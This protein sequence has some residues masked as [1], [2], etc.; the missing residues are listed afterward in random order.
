MGWEK[1]VQVRRFDNPARTGSTTGL[2]RTRASGLVYVQV[3]W[4]DGT[5]DYV[6]EDQIEA[7]NSTALS[8]PYAVIEAGRYGR[9][10]DLRRS[11]TQV[12]LSGRLAN[13][14]YS[15]GI[16]NTDF[17]AYQY[18]PLLTLLESPADGLLIADEVGLGKTI[19]AGI[20]WTELRAR[21]DMRRLLIVC[22]AMLR[23][24]WQEELQHRFGIDAMI[25]DARTLTE[26]LKR[27]SSSGPIKAW[28]A[29]YQSLRPP[30]SWRPATEE[31][32]GLNSARAL[33]ADLLDEH[34][35][36]DPLVDLV[37][38]DEAH[39]MR[40]AESSA[41]RLGELLREVSHYRVLLSATPINLHN[42]D[43][44]QLLR[45]CDPE[46]FQYQ[47]SFAEMIQANQPLVKARDAA[48][49]LNGT[50]DE[51]IGHLREAAATPMLQG[52][53]QLASILESPPTEMGLL[54]QRYRAD[55]AASLERVNLLGHVVTRTRKRDVQL[56]RPKRDVQA[57]S[58]PMTATERSFY[59]HVT[60]MTRDYAMRKGISDGFLLVMPQR[61]VCSCPAA[62][63]QAWMNNDESLVED[64]AQAVME[65]IEEVDEDIDIEEISTSLKEFLFRNRP[66]ALDFA[67]LERDDSKLKR[68]LE[69]AR[70]YFAEHPS[71]KIVLFTSFRATARYLQLKLQAAGMGSMLIWGNM[72]ETKQD[73]IHEFESR[74]DLRVLVSTEVAAEGVD[75]QFCKV[76]VNYD[77]PWNPMR[78][79]QRIGRIDRLGQ[80]A[81]KIHIW[82]LFYKGTIDER[83]LGRL[84]ERLKIFTESLGEPEPIIGEIIQRLE[85]DLLTNKLTPEEE[86]AK[87][88]QAAQ[89]L[90]NVRKRQEELEQNAV[91]MIAH[92]GMV[93]ERIEAAQELARRVTELD[94]VVYVHD[95]LAHHA[96]GHQFLQDPQQAD[97]YTIQ[98]P[99]RTAAELDDF[100]RRNGMSGQTSL[101]NG[102]ARQC[103][104][105]N[106]IAG[107]RNKAVESVHQFHPLVRFISDRLRASEDALYP[108]V[109]LRLTVSDVPGLDTGRYF[110]LLR[111]W[112][113]EGVKS[114]EILVPA[115]AK[116]GSDAV[117][118]E[119]ESDRF[120]N[121]ARLFG[122]DW[123]EVTATTPPDEATAM[124]DR[125]ED[126]LERQY[127]ITVQRKQDENSDRAMF[128]LRG[129]DQHLEA[130]ERVLLA[131]LERHH[132]LRRTGLAKATQG[133][134]DKLRARLQMKREQIQR[135]QRV[136]PNNHFVCCGMVIVVEG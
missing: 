124:L 91:Q 76:L 16:T 100:A 113:F 7:V 5:M 39:Y 57:E 99:P 30:R 11:L 51:I 35:G 42:Q 26:E 37:V 128:Q 121:A 13:L 89:A 47:S 23:E 110:F 74:P 117:L 123:L 102:L 8:D 44:Y 125:L 109:A 101:G 59:V 111:R 107:A 40:N 60:E 70:G 75:L 9:A 20:I 25:V 93:L 134:I 68:L 62:F 17:Y 52:S 69:V 6:A 77:L 31:R 38:F 45:L 43:L 87:I 133:R 131:T 48:L 28:I 67:A 104:F 85:A 1:G 19:E 12:H 118:T 73:L 41:N 66:H 82:N 58:V 129:L 132:L 136:A 50:A 46:H 34:D 22:P 27:S 14:V 120:M 4:L 49:R 86:E 135:Q 55:L 122:A 15:M 119:E 96:Q 33:L 116:M 32:T 56:H 29:S 103:R 97:L 92:G 108:A 72:K 90:E 112:V 61:Q 98:L 106:K 88:A 65:D 24:K 78:V 63:A 95:F 126:Q 105:L 81:D 71:E 114:E 80:S 115:V 18:R 3:R 36:G 127:R 83:I 64:M 94:L 54:S 84:L 21:E 10:A 79:E 130:R 2:E 53:R